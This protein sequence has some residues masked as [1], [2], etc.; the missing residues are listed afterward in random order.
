M[1]IRLKRFSLNLSKGIRT[2]KPLVIQGAES[3]QIKSK[4]GKIFRRRLQQD[5]NLNRGVNLNLGKE[6]RELESEKKQLKI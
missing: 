4:G 1:I 5:I 6:L 3:T 2:P